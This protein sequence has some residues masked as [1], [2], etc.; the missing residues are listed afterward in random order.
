M[1]RTPTPTA[2]F[3]DTQRRALINLMTAPGY[4]HRPCADARSWDLTPMPRGASERLRERARR[5]RQQ[6]IRH[7]AR[8]CRT[9]PVLAWCDAYARTRPHVTGVIAGRLIGEAS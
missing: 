3:T 6:E 8:A 1:T 4:E 2:L 5:D 9:C 7:R